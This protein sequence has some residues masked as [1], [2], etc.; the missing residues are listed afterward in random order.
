MYT[1]LI[2]TLRI[3]TYI[4]THYI[5]I[6]TLLTFNSGAVVTATQ[7]TQVNKLLIGQL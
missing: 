6:L 7:Y 3:K 2:Y 4:H 1:V 5:N